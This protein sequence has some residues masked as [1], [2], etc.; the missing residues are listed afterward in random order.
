MCTSCILFN[1]IKHQNLSESHLV[2]HLSNIVVV[3]NLKKP[4]IWLL[5]Q[6]EEN[7]Q[8]VVMHHCVYSTNQSILYNAGMSWVSLLLCYCISP[9]ISK[10]QINPFCAKNI[11]HY[12]VLTKGVHCSGRVVNYPLMIP[13]WLMIIG[14]LIYFMDVKGLTPW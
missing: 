13:S 7:Q 14:C 8:C 6:F 4:L 9:S 1:S 10:F 2:F 11:T 3:A 5:P 12:N